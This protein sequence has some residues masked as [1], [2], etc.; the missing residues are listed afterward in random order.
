MELDEGKFSRTASRLW[1]EIDLELRKYWHTEDPSIQVISLRFLDFE[2]LTEMLSDGLQSVTID[3][4]S[5]TVTLTG[6]EANKP[7][8][9][10]IERTYFLDFASVST[11]EQMNGHAPRV[12]LSRTQCAIAALQALVREAMFNCVVSGEALSEAIEALEDIVWV[13]DST[14]GIVQDRHSHMMSSEDRGSYAEMSS[15]DD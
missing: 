12:E 9:A 13:A 3:V 10:C 15:M 6:Q 7:D 8:S 1:Y 5:S 14:D 4:E 11:K 2:E